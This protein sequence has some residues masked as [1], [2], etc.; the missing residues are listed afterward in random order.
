[1]CSLS[2]NHWRYILR[3]LSGREINLILIGIGTAA[4]AMFFLGGYDYLFL[5]ISVPDEGGTYTEGIVGEPR[6]INPA[7]S[8]ANEVD[9][10]ITTLIFSGL[11]KH[12]E[13]G[14]IVPDLAESYE[15]K[16]D[17]K[18]YEFTLRENLL[19]PDKTPITSDDVIFTINLIKDAKY[20]SP[21][22]N[23]WQGVKT[24]KIDGR[25]LAL[26]LSVEYEPFLENATLGIMPKH[27]WEKV[28]PQS[29]L[30]TQLNSKP[31][32]FGP[33]QLKKITK[34]ASGKIKSMEFSPNEKYYEKA[35]ISTILLRF[36]ETQDDLINAFKRREI[37]GFSLNS[38]LEKELIKSRS[39]NF[40][41]VKLPRYFGVF[42][43]QDKSK[44]LSDLEVRKALAMSTDKKTIV[45]E[46]LKNEA[47][48]QDGPFPYGLLEI[49]DP[50]IIYPFDF[51]KAEEVLDKAGWKMT[52]EG[53]REKKLKGEKN[54]TTLEFTLTTT[55]W[56]ELTQVA[57]IL[58]RDWEKIGVKINLDIVPVSAMQTQSI[59]PR[60]YEALLFGEVL[61]LN[62]DPF[63]FW[64]STQRK[65]P[66][67]N[68]S[69]Y[70]N[71]KVDGLLEI[72]RQ[73]IDPEI[74]SSKYEEFQKII[75]NEIPAIFLYSP[76]YIYAMLPKIKGMD[77]QAINTPSQRFENLNKW[78]I[79][80][81]RVSK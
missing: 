19:W 50:E 37:D 73:E 27:I 51:V 25:T 12:N 52:E 44:V 11:V 38:P 41:D 56:P 31:I 8:V 5:R 23:M 24:E 3:K 10:D 78:Y 21:L 55:D 61:T 20:Q 1:L 29:F 60:E 26:K 22:R 45:E 80:T 28:S 67:L 32:G 81:K 14:E 74:K 33:Y 49:K 9:R 59:R 48:I 62:P 16:D 4:A 63:S 57:S 6:Y 46:V 35:N 18:T 47:E 70:N 72:A 30:L 7:V 77:T 42:F 54:A 43:N 79:A 13:M 71:K 2:V 15:I 75:I 66:G 17:G 65:D 64:H 39:V 69:M 53:L 68:L 58:K 36:Y 34:S 76:N 40:Y